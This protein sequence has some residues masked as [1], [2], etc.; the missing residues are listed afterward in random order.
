MLFFFYFFIIKLIVNHEIMQIIVRAFQFVV[1]LYLSYFQSPFLHFFQIFMYVFFLSPFLNYFVVNFK[2]SSVGFACITFQEIISIL[3]I[4]IFWLLISLF[5]LF[6]QIFHHWCQ[7][8][9]IFQHFQLG[10]TDH[11]KGRIRS[12]L[13]NLC[14]GHN[15]TPKRTYARCILFLA[16]LKAVFSLCC[17]N[18]N[19][20]FTEV[21][22]FYFPLFKNAFFVFYIFFSV[23]SISFDFQF[24]CLQIL[25]FLLFFFYLSLR[26]ICIVPPALSL[27]LKSL[28]LN[29]YHRCFSCFTLP[30]LIPNEFPQTSFIAFIICFAFFFYFYLSSKLTS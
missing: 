18:L 27:Y 7:R 24:K 17:F 25:S 15:C 23:A 19:F 4:Y 14:I 1:F 26:F 28:C 11:S 29:P 9:Q 3:F 5:L 30:T 10:H 22:F 13:G 20:L 2:P 8:F 21:V 12:Y 6:H 16:V